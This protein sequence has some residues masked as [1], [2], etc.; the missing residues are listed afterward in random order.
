MRST[1]TDAG[2]S[3]NDQNM[4]I[5]S[6]AAGVSLP[7]EV[8]GQMFS[9]GAEG[10]NIDQ[11]TM[12]Q[13]L[14]ETSSFGESLKTEMSTSA[15]YSETMAEQVSSASQEQHAAM[16]SLGISDSLTESSSDVLSATRALSTYSDDKSSIGTIEK[17]NTVDMAQRVAESDNGLSNLSQNY[18]NATGLLSKD[19]REEV[20]NSVASQAAR[21][22]SDE[23]GMAPN[24]A[25]ARAQ[26]EALASNVFTGSEDSL[27]RAA[28]YEGLVGAYE[29]S[30]GKNIGTRGAGELFNE[31][32]KDEIT[33]GN[34]AVGIATASVDK[35]LDQTVTD[36]TGV[37]TDLNG[38]G[39]GKVRPEYDQDLVDMKEQ[40][41]AHQGQFNNF[42]KAA[43]EWNAAQ[44]T[45]DSG[46]TGVAAELFGSA[47]NFSRFS[48]M[49]EDTAGEVSAMAGE[50]YSEGR[51]SGLSHGQAAV[52]SAYYGGA[53]TQE[54]AGQ[55][56]RDE[57]VGCVAL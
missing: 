42:T 23:I 57:M 24:A 47:E 35:G 25:M 2:V 52:Y 14:K 20:G 22:S 6:Y 34:A 39:L 17:F 32:E 16:Q 10:K 45:F 53:E 7:K 56:L 9:A 1:M 11:Q 28:G 3:L 33:A 46:S 30:T 27:V 4:I 36:N 49:G 12:A 40:A 38:S 13:A 19:E 31:K 8:V 51:S 44:R 15:T 5:G 37:T 43:S 18:R 55:V 50:L 29:D 54:L 41:T 21:Y 48:T 26:M